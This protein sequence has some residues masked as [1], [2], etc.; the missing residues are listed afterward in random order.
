MPP[1]RGLQHRMI[2]T[3]LVLLVLLFG[4]KANTEPLGYFE[5]VTDGDTFVLDSGDKVR[6]IGVDCPESLDPLKPVEY[7]S[8]EATHFL[9]SLIGG[10]QVRLE[11][12]DE[13]TDRYGRLLCYVWIDDSIL[14]NREIVCQGYGMAFLRYPHDREPEFL[15][16]ELRARREGRGMWASPRSRSSIRSPEKNRSTVN[17][18]VTVYVTRTGSKYHRGTCQYLSMSKIPMSK[19][20]AISGGYGEC[21]RCRP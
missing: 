13:R 20:D 21:S 16:C 6:L 2:C 10:K 3:Y 14:V 12:G 9:D 7:F 19:A 5:R 1:R 8:A 15:E 11:Y 18:T 4:A 17:D